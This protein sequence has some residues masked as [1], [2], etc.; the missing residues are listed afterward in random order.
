MEGIEQKRERERKRR[1]EEGRGWE[2]KIDGKGI[3]EEERGGKDWERRLGKG[4]GRRD[5]KKRRV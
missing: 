5:Q 1:R 2:R 3:E 4:E